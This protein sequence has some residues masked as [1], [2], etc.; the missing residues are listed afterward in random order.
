MSKNL[1]L[2]IV[3]IA[4]VALSAA[5]DR[6]R[7]AGGLARGWSM[8][9]KLLPHFL[10]LLIAVG[11]FLTLMPRDV[12]AD[13][14]GRQSGILAP[15]TAAF[16]GAVALI[17]GPIAYPLAGMMQ[18]NGVS[19]RVIAV[20]VTTLMMVG[21]LTLPVEKEH[22]GFRIAILRNVLSFLGTL[23]IGFIVGE[24]L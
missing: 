24:L 4:A 9:R 5:A 10:L 14:L 3:I 13:F 17:P 16:L 7:T 6:R 18:Q 11:V 21:M 15:I 12:L 1:A 2:A 20:F 19:T 23:I 22:F 8:L